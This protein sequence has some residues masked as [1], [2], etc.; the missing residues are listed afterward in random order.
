VSAGAVRPPR[1]AHPAIPHAVFLLLAFAAAA[2]GGRF[3]PDAWYASL[4]RPGLTP[5]GW[6][7]GPVWTVLYA[8]IGVAGGLVWRRA[9][10][11]LPIALW[12]LQLGLNAAWSWLFFGLHRPGVAFADIAALWL[13]IVATLVAFRR[14][15]RTA[16]YLFVPYLL[17][18][19]FAKYLNW[20]FWRLN[21]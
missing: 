3:P 11:S 21:S 15:H 1:A 17:W 9:G 18:V 20:G 2:V 14:V 12:G 16:A 4:E 8:C 6:L 5:P 13:A 10:F 19:T 7:F